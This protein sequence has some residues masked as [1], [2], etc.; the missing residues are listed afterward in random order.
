MT[1]KP[2]HN[3]SVPEPRSTTQPGPQLGDIGYTFVKIFPGYGNFRGTVIA[4][5][6][7]ASEFGVWCFHCFIIICRVLG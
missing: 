4:I 6:K 3:E 7:G 5:R 2:I 1:S